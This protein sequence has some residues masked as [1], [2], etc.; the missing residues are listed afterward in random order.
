MFQ[1]FQKL[2]YPLIIGSGVYNT[3]ISDDKVKTGISQAS[4]ITS[5]YIF[6]KFSEKGL[7]L[8]ADKLKQN[9]KIANCKPALLAISTI[10]GLCFVFAS[11]SGYDI[12]N[13]AASRLVDK[14]RKS[15]GI[16]V[17][18]KVETSKT[19]T[20]KDN[21]SN[22]LLNNSNTNSENILLDENSLNAI[23]SKENKFNNVKLE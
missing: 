4:A 14:Y 5:M 12:G 23:K 2:V 19:E 10:K 1:L 17:F 8:I 3:Y 21:V 11:M 9:S 20:A 6:E 18:E 15:N 13:L 22:P 7:K 16:D